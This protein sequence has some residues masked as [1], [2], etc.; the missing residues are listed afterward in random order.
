MSDEQ[1]NFDGGFCSKCE[2]WYLPG[3]PHAL[4]VYD[5]STG[6]MRMTD[7]TFDLTAFR[8]STSVLDELRPHNPITDERLREVLLDLV[9]AESWHYRRTCSVCGEEWMSL[10]CK[11]DGHQKA[12]PNGHYNDPVLTDD[13][14]CEF[15]KTEAVAIL[16][17]LIEEARQ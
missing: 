7:Q 17:K 15:D 13:C 2:Q 16:R 3:Q 10:H 4:L 12:C 8:M 14:E 6:Q 5:P 1:H 9:E 11:H